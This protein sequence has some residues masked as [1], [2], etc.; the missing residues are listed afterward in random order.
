VAAALAERTE[1]V[2]SGVTFGL[3][4]KYRRFADAAHAMFYLADAV[5]MVHHSPHPDL[6][7]LED[8]GVTVLQR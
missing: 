5:T 6:D 2:P 1:E 4:G 3:P 8:R 7:Q